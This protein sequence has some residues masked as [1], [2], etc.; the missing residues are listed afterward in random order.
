MFSL[1]PVSGK[2]GRARLC[3]VWGVER[4]NYVRGRKNTR[5]ARLGRCAR[6]RTA[7]P[8]LP[9][10]LQSWRSR[11]SVRTGDLARNVVRKFSAVTAVRYHWIRVVES[12]P[13]A[14]KQGRRWLLQTQLLL[15]LASTATAEECPYPCVCHVNADAARTL[16]VD[17]R[18]Q[19]LFEVPLGVPPTTSHLSATRSSCFSHCHYNVPPA[20]TSAIITFSL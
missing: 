9:L 12:S 3:A 10:F 19:E 14:M 13:L 2:R 8:R 5:E 1:L 16:T 6:A 15:F 18:N 11:R 4:S 17:C 20:V 7:E